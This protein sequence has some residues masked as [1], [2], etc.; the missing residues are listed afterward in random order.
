M[1]SANDIASAI[2]AKPATVRKRQQRALSALRERLGQR[3]HAAIVILA[4]LMAAGQRV[5]QLLVLVLVR[6]GKRRADGA[7][8][9]IAP[10]GKEATVDPAAVSHLWISAGERVPRASGFLNGVCSWKGAALVCIA[11]VWR[12]LRG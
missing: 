4:A 10:T 12:C 2:D 5:Q 1:V 7:G 8:E 11:T 3:G 9:L 6:T